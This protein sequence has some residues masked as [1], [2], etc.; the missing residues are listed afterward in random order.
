MG[1]VNLG[2]I[3]IKMVFEA[4]ILDEITEGGSVDR[5]ENLGCSDLEVREMRRNDQV[6]QGRPGQGRGP[7]WGAGLGSVSAAH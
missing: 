1:R 3:S 4:V 5:E 2:V 6:G 7:E